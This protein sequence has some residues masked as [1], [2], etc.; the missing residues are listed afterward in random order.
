MAGS[1][2]LAAD[3]ICKR[4]HDIVLNW[5][6]GLHHARKSMASGFCYI[7]DIVLSI[8]HMLET[9]DKVVYI[10]IDV[11]HGDGVQEAFW[12]TNRVMTVSFHLYDPENHFFPS[13]GDIDEIG[14]FAGKNYSINVPLKAG[15]SD[16]TY[17]KVFETI[18]DKVFDYYRPDA[19]FLQCGADSLIGDSLGQFNISILGHAEA[20]NYVVKKGYPTILSGGGGYVP[21]NV[22]RCWAY[23]SSVV[24]GKRIDENLPDNLVYSHEYSDKRFFYNP[25]NTFGITKDSNRSSDISAIIEACYKAMPSSMANPAIHNRNM[26]KMDDMD[27]NLSKKH[28]FILDSESEEE[29]QYEFEII[30]N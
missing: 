3:L 23:E 12:T 19:V 17:K 27:Y 21:E 7:N 22:A 16:A 29:I 8:M 10:D 5:M 24:L 14:E 11:H 6:G 9:Y 2:I 28:K 18:I 30:I 20:V 26:I 15:C 13:T 1:S 4:E 25:E